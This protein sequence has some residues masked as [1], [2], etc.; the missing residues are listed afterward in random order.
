MHRGSNRIARI[1]AAV[2]LVIPVL[3]L[4]APDSTD[5]FAHSVRPNSPSVRIGVLGLFHSH[6]FTVTALPGRA[7]AVNGGSEEMILETSSGTARSTVRMSET[8]IVASA[9]DHVLRARTVQFTGRNGQSAPFQLAIPGKVIRKYEGTLEFEPANGE[10]TAI[11]TMDLETA[12]ASV[13]AAEGG[14]VTPLE[15]I[16][17]QAIATRSYLIAGRGR[18]ADFDFCD[19]T[20]CQFLREPPN[21]DSPVARAVSA[22]RGLLLAYNSQPFPSMYTRS[23]SGRTKTAAQVG[24]SSDAYPYY[25]VE[26]KFCISHPDRWTRRIP[27]K[28]APPLHSSDEGSRLLV[29]RRLGWN[30]VPSNDFISTKSGN[31]AILQGTGYGHGIGLC[32]A[33]ARAMAEDGAAFSEILAHYYPNTTLV[34]WTFNH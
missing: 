16:R 12:V 18:H 9:G 30:A 33:G 27:A 23:C 20:H 21:P 13:V 5:A 10:L 22:T 19:T 29:V 32:Q 7:L 2:L 14:S 8:G 31:E 24:L 3:P 1:A 25:A 15:A 26:C 6:I 11:I 34:E 4:R 28:D 17:A